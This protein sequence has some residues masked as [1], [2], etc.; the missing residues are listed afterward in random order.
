MYVVRCPDTLYCTL[1]L[2]EVHLDHTVLCYVMMFLSTTD[3]IYD[4]S[5]IIL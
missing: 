3:R 1:C 5:P 4:G 2:N